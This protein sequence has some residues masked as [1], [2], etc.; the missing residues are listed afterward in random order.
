MDYD[1]LV[2]GE[3]NVDLILRGADVMPEFGQVEKI[4]EDASLSLGS[5]SAIFACGASRLGL[6]VGF[7]GKVGDDEFGHY[8]IHTLS[9]RNVDTSP[10]IIDP[11]IKTGLTV[12][13]SSGHDRAMLT[14]LGSIAAMTGKDLDDRLIGRTRHIHQSSFF[15]QRGL[16]SDLP[17]YL[18][19]ARA[20]GV[21]VSMDPGWD[22]QVQWNRTIQTAL[23]EVDIF[24]PNEQEALAILQVPTLGQAMEVC[25][26]QFQMAVIKRGHLGSA[27]CRGNELTSLP[28][29]PVKVTDTV[30]AGDSFDA[31]FLYGYLHGMDLQ[32]CL[33][34]GNA[35]GALSTTGFGGISAQPTVAEVESFLLIQKKRGNAYEK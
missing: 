6:R 30:G 14:Y 28:V 12:H 10:I 18:A 3:L 2:I 8:L 1:I 23:R 35:C 11:G 19:K 25:Q 13:L 20:A 22:P 33:A 32:D 4:V 9:T 21:T 26:Q 24:M 5:S 15:M 31:G 27:A 17:G 7:T 16:H 34:W 29:F